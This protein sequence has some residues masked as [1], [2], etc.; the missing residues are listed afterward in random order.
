MGAGSSS[1]SLRT[2]VLDEMRSSGRVLEDFEKHDFDCASVGGMKTVYMMFHS[3]LEELQTQYTVKDEGLVVCSEA[4]EVIEKKKKVEKQQ[5]KERPEPNV[6]S[7]MNKLNNVWEEEISLMENAAGVFLLKL[8]CT[9]RLTL[10]N[11]L[12]KIS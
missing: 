5:E 2:N 1:S 3:A 9:V 12:D 10:N 4:S 7:V 6:D 8:L 11:V